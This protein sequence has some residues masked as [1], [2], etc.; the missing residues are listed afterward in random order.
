M[1]TLTTLAACILFALTS[2]SSTQADQPTI[3]AGVVNATC[4]LQGDDV[5]EGKVVEYKGHLIGMCCDNCVAA[6]DDLTVGQKDSALA[7]ALK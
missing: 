5:V 7:T 4:P 2:C 1:K 3:Q 6:W